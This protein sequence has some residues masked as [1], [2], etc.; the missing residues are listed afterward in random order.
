MAILHSDQLKVQPAQPESAKM[1]MQFQSVIKKINELT[2]NNNG[3]QS[4]SVENG[5]ENGADK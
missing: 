3:Q 5:S 1:C 2:E 4:N